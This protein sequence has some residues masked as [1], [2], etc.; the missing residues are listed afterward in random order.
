[1]MSDAS[2]VVVLGGTILRKNIQEIEFVQIKDDQIPIG[3]WNVS[4]DKKGEIWA[5][6][7][8]VN[9]KI[10]LYIGSRNGVYA[11]TN[12][13]DF[14]KKYVNLTKIQFN[15]LF[16]TCKV[17]NMSGMFS[18]CT[19]LENIDLESFD[20]ENV[21]DMSEMFF[22]CTGLREIN[23]KKFN[24]ETVEDM[25]CMFCNCQNLRI[26]D[27]SSFVTI[28]VKKMRSMF[29]HCEKLKNLKIAK[30]NMKKLIDTSYMFG[31]CKKIKS[32]DVFYFYNAVKDNKNIVKDFMYDGC[33]FFYSK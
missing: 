29:L 3:A 1:M 19:S 23:L 11:N 30:F 18:Y 27:I 13:S 28:N 6:N 17:T 32:S 14:L 25:S 20:T 15:G 26:L 2:E 5:W 9:K 8:V 7:E 31:G 16:D 12:C 22:G 4:E 24:T 21:T 33:N 10:K